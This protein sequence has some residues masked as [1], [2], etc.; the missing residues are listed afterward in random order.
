MYDENGN[1]MGAEELKNEMGNFWKGIYQ[2]HNNDV[3]EVWNDITREAYLQNDYIDEDR[4]NMVYDVLR[5]DRGVFRMVDI[6]VNIPL[7]LTEHYSMTRGS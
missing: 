6:R 5:L 4:T 7:H 2:M 3:R 1:E